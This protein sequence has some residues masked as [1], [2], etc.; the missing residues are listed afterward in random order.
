[1]I[2]RRTIQDVSKEIPIYPNPV[3]RPSPKPVK[4]S[5]SKVPGSLLDI[6]SEVNTDFEE[7]SPFQE[8]VISETYQRPDKSYFQEP[9]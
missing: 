1:M 6:D 5:I 8:G 7:N 4:T 3:Y 9:Q 2:D